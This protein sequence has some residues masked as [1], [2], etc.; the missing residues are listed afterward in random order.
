MDTAFVVLSVAQILALLTAAVIDAVRRPDRIWTH[1]LGIGALLLISVLSCIDIFGPIP[2]AT[3]V[4][5]PGL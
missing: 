4:K 1:W 5:E 3:S 2:D